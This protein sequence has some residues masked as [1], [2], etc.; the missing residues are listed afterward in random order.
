MDPSK[1]EAVAQW[2]CPET[3]SELRLFLGFSSYY[4]CFVDGFAKQAAPLHKLLVVC[5]ER[6]G[7]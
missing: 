1:V 3:V 4:H 5:G 6:P 2:C 7:K